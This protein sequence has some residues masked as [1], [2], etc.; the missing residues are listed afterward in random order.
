MA[1]KTGRSRG[2]KS[3]KGFVAIPFT[4][5]ITLGTLASGTVLKMDN[6]IVPTEDLF[7][8][9]VDTTWT[10]RNL[11]AGEGP[12]PIGWAHNDLTVTEIGESIDATM[13]NP[14][15][16]IARERSRRPVRKAGTFHGLSSEE[17]LNDGM[18]VRTKCKFSVGETGLTAY[19]ANRSGANL[20]TGA[21]ILLNGT[22]Y[23][24]WQV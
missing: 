23:G 14:N 13:L 8:I 10:I 7:V 22:I 4:D 21:I 1:R 20:T 12:L 5:A 19:V 24:R 9:S 11:T 17:S 16:I 3:R 15:D 6:P 18:P 2:R